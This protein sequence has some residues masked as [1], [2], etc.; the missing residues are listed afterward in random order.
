MTAPASAG[1][2]GSLRQV[3][4]RLISS[5]ES[6]VE[7]FSV[8]LQEEKFRLLQNFIWIS[9]AIFVG[10]MAMAFASLTV[11]YAFW[12]TARLAALAGLT[13]FYAAAFVAIIVLFRRHLARQPRPFGDTRRELAADR[14]CF[15]A[16]S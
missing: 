8:E 2:L 9:A 5:L 12:E 1:F 13:L 10:A 7:L 4:E 6:R 3:G 16:E 14:A 11:V 15:R